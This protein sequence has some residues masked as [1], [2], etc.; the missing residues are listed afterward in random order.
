MIR[1][2][3]HL[4]IA[5]GK[6]RQAVEWVKEYERV[7]QERIPEHPRIRAL[8]PFSGEVNSLILEA[9]Y[10]DLAHWDRVRTAHQTDSEVMN[11]FR[12]PLELL[13]PGVKPW[14]AFEE[15]VTQIA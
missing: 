15:D 3:L 14:D 6:F 9:E 10:S 2:R 4:S 13:T 7:T 8:V 12:K 1:Q 5:P 11:V